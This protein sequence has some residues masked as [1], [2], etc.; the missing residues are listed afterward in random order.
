MW[1][2]ID[3]VAYVSVPLSLWAF[4]FLSSHL[5]STFTIATETG[6]PPF[7]LKNPGAEARVFEPDLTGEEQLLKI[8]FDFRWWFCPCCSGVSGLGVWGKGFGFRV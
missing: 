8:E 4:Y 2:A 7:P 3:W 6:Q 5:K 1:N